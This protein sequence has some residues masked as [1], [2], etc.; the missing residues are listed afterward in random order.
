VNVEILYVADLPVSS[1]RAVKLVRD[2]LAA[3]GVAAETAV[4]C[5][6]ETKEMA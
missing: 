6:S 1:R 3:E 5:S 2:V 4:R